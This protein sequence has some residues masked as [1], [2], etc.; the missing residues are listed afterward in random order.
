MVGLSGVGP[1]SVL[2]TVGE[3]VGLFVE[4]GKVGELVISVGSVGLAVST[5]MLIVGDTEGGFV[6][7]DTGGAV[8]SGGGVGT[9][10]GGSVGCVNTFCCGVKEIARKQG[11][12]LE[13]LSSSSRDQQVKKRK[14][15]HETYR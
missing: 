3:L 2:A 12:W 9:E 15:Q 4:S 6:I 5:S 13:T 7:P 8:S 1:S 14:S 11:Q 10:R